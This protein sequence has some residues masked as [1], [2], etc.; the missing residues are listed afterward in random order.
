MVKGHY[1]SKYG[2]SKNG[3]EKGRRDTLLVIAMII[4]VL[5]LAYF[6]YK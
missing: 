2:G 6:L 3:W 4:V 1:T 5:S